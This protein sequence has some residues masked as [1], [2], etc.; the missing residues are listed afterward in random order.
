MPGA[1]WWVEARGQVVSRGVSG[2]AIREPSSAP[3]REDTPYDGASLTKPLVTGLLLAILDH[4]GVLD[5][6]EPVGRWVEEARGSPLAAVSLLELARHEGGLPAWLPLYLRAEDRAGYLRQIAQAAR[7]GERGHC[8]YSDLGYIALGVAIERAGGADLARLFDSRIAGPLGLRHTGFAGP[9]RSFPDAA[10]TE[11][12]NAYERELAGVAGR[13][14]EWRDHID[15]G[16]VHDGNAWGLGGVAGHAGLFLTAEEAAA[17]AREIVVPRCLA[18]GPRGRS[19][20]L[21]APTAGART[22][23]FV[24]AEQSQAARGIL[25]CGSPGHTG[26]TGTSLWLDPSTEGVYVLLTNRVHPTVSSRNFQW[27]RRAFHRV[28]RRSVRVA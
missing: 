2:L 27:L 24:P 26:F 25:P 9:P 23:G 3:V 1:S 28:V 18:L 7:A 11:R 6:S 22:A 15:R 19:H 12:G 16:V 20:L 17:L 8:V 4:E 14:Y 5:A 13:G 21:R 10:A